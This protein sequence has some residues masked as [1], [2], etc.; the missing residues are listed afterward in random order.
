MG[1]KE[2]RR[3][4][5]GDHMLI[6]KRP[7]GTLSYCVGYGPVNLTDFTWSWGNMIQYSNEYCCRASQG[8]YLHQSCGRSSDVS[9]SRNYLSKA[10][11]GDWL[12]M[13]DCDHAFEPDIVA[14][15]LSLFNAPSP[16]G[17][18]VDVLSGFYRYRAHPYLPVVF[19]FDEGSGLHHNIGPVDF[20][21][22]IIRIHGCTGA[23]CLMVRRSVFDRIARELKEEPFTRIPPVGEDFSFGHR[24]RRLG[25]KWWLAPRIKSDHLTVK[26]V[27]DADFDLN[28]VEVMDVPA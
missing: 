13:T 8:E 21:Q 11:L 9:D 25:I 15:M 14:R 28:A 5:W 2:P 23:G 24:L 17:D 4:N 6:F 19:H 16:D 12:W 18:R 3:S 27:T 22:H 1:L 20:S 26:R 10:F 7:I